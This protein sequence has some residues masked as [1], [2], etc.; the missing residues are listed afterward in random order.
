MLKPQSILSVVQI[1]LHDLEAG[2]S[3]LIAVAMFLPLLCELQ[4]KVFM[5]PLENGP[6]RMPSKCLMVN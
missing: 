3:N 4:T 1:S 6:Q 5:V 2:F